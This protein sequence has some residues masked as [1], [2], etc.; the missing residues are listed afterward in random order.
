V[1]VWVLYNWL[2][3]YGWERRHGLMD[4][5]LVSSKWRLDA[6]KEVTGIRILGGENWGCSISGWSLTRQGT[7]AGHWSSVTY[8]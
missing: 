3:V 2:I 8:D 6:M 1:L 7:A 5:H 4:V